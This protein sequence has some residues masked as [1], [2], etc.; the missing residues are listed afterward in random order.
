[1]LYWRIE[2]S[3]WRNRLLTRLIRNVGHMELV[4]GL[5]NT[6]VQVKQ[7][8]SENS[9]HIKVDSFWPESRLGLF[10]RA[11]VLVFLFLFL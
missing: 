7:D 11:Y 5:F 4:N 8:I 9:H 1:M 2:V 10:P 6:I 3:R